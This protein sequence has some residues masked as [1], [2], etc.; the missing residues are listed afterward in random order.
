MEL[1]RANEQ[2]D[3]GESPPRPGPFENQPSRAAGCPRW[4]S[5]VFWMQESGTS[6]MVVGLPVLAVSQDRAPAQPATDVHL[7]RERQLA[8]LMNPIAMQWNKTGPG[9][10]VNSSPVVLECFRAHFPF[11]PGIT[12]AA[13]GAETRSAV[14]NPVSHLTETNLQRNFR[15]SRALCGEGKKRSFYAWGVRGS[16]NRPGLRRIL[17]GEIAVEAGR[18]LSTPTEWPCQGLCESF[19]FTL[20]SPSAPDRANGPRKPTGFP[21]TTLVPPN[22]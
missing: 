8:A 3:A 6:L 19:S 2:A 11:R 18:E 15:V 5:M 14:K 12:S 17:Q 20:P 16:K 21:P 4:G 10:D 9:T 13:L 22:P 1:N 7:L